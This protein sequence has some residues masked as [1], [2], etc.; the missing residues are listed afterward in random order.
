MTRPSHDTL[1]RAFD[2]AQF[3]PSRTLDLRS[4]LPTPVEAVR[5]AETWLREKQVTK[6]GDVLIITGRGKGSPN[7]I[8]VVREAVRRLLTTLQRKGV[9]AATGT[10]TAGSFVVTLAPLRALFEVPPRKRAK[11]PRVEPADPAELRALAP[12]TRKQLRWLAERSLESLGAPRSEGF[13]LDEMKRQFAIL[14]SMVARDEADR[15]GRL[16]FLIS[17][18]H[19]AFDGA[20]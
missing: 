10:H 19:D 9:V 5:R 14:S 13:V 2:D 3:G 8:G 16:Q 1:A 20:E 6:A 11:V 15:E 17:V 12:D 7:G 4:S 18:T